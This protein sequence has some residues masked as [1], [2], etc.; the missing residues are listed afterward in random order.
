MLINKYFKKVVFLIKLIAKIFNSSQKSNNK[1]F[2]KNYKK[3][4]YKN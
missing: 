1:Q 3:Y 4:V 2:L